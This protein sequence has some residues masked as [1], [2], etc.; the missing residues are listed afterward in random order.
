[1]VHIKQLSKD[2]VFIINQL[3]KEIWPEAFKDI[4][5]AKQIEYMLDWMYDIN[6]LEDQ[7]KIGHL[8]FLV[9]LDGVPQGFLGLEPNYPDAGM[10][11]IH[12]L[13]VKPDQHNTGLGKALLLKAEEIAHTLDFDSINLNVNRFNKAVGFYEHFGFET[14]KEEDIDI[15]RDYLMEDFVMVKKI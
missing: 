2:E 15:G 4:L 8:F 3:A 14:V 7:A 9:T 6:T 11:R 13:Y 1:M 5:S 12:K 10:L